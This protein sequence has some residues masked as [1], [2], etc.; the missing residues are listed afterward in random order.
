MVA[1]LLAQPLADK[2]ISKIEDTIR[3]LTTRGVVQYAL[4]YAGGDSSKPPIAAAGPLPD[5]TPNPNRYVTATNPV[6]HKSSPTGPF[7]DYKRQITHPDDAQQVLGQIRMGQSLER[8]FADLQGMIALYIAIAAAAL[9]LAVPAAFI[10]VQRLVSPIHALSRV[11]YRFGKGDFSA[12][13]HL[14]RDDEIGMLAEGFD[15]MADHLAKAHRDMLALN[16]ELEERVAER[17]LQLQELASR[18]PLTGLYNRRH[19]NEILAGRFA[20]SK[21]HGG[22]LTCMMMDLDDFKCVNDQSGHH[23]GDRVLI[24]AAEVIRKQLRS[25][26]VAARFGGDEFVILLPW[27]DA[28]QARILAERISAQF[29]ARCES[30]GCWSRVTLS[31]GIAST[32]DGAIKD[33][34]DLVKKADQALYQA[35]AGGKRRVETAG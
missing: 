8:T 24:Y 23:E 22:N 34:E 11:V 21:R 30:E 14:D 19:F 35:K 32:A 18:E 27:T 2:D 31:I 28:D 29:E 1:S 6:F 15:K 7:F 3:D 13:S 16:V 9:L 26:D 25:E 33:A 4:V 5:L 17:T 12:R 10:L 20:E